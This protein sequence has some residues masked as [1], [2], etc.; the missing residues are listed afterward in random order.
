MNAEPRS[1][2][3]VFTEQPPMLRFST[4]L[5]L[6]LLCCLPSTMVADEPPSLEQEL[7]AI[8][9]EF[10]LPG[11]A[12]GIVL[13]QGLQ[14]MAAVGFRKSG[15]EVRV[16]KQDLWHLGSCTK[17]MTATLLA[18]LVQ[19]G[20]LAWN[21]TLFE[22]FPELQAQMSEDFRQITLEHLLT[23][24]SGLPANGAWHDLGSDRTTTAQRVELLRRQLDQPL[25]HPPGAKYQYSN[26]GYAL[27]GL[28]AEQKTL[29]MSQ[30]GFGIPGTI[31]DTDQPWGHR[32]TWFGLGTLQPVQLDNAASLGPAGTV[33]AALEDWAKFIALHLNRDNGLVQPEVWDKLH[34]AAA[35]SDYAMGWLV[36]ERQWAKDTEGKGLALTHAGSN[37]ANY[38][39]CWLAPQAGFAALAVC[40]SG[41]SN[42]PRALDRTIG[43]LIRRVP[44]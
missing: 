32:T 20:Q 16:T 31:G 8:R 37:T 34:T 11:L 10:D 29:G 4:I 7:E 13:R 24:R 36:A 35:G 23:H 30:V 38:C 18:T 27:A 9:Q 26:V 22:L 25:D 42:A 1:L 28:M 2:P 40:N 19:E 33:H 6:A 15:S 41:Q 17:A 3:G 14:D 5:V 43:A 44:R 21:T 12:G 39:V